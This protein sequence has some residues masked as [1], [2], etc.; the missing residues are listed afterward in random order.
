M[1]HYS[2]IKCT[3]TINDLD[4]IK[5]ACKELG[6]TFRVG[7]KVRFYYTHD[8]QTADYVISIPGSRYDVGLKKD[9]QGNLELVYDKYDG[10]V[11]K[12]LGKDCHKLIQSTV[13]H[14]I[15][16]HAKLNRKFVAKRR[17]GDSL[18]VEITG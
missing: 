7:G 5:D 16:R 17:V 14:K 1:S 15:V 8:E 12:V 10:S 3:L 6:L 2:T 18:F 11:E 13:Y 4:F 9:K